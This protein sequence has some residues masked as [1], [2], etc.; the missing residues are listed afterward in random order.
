MNFNSIQPNWPAPKGI[1]AL[2]ST[3][4]G[5]VSEGLYESLNLAAHV[6]DEPD[7]VRE[8]RLRFQTSLGLPEEPCWLNQCHGIRAVELFPDTTHIPFSADA[9]YTRAAGKVCAVLTADCLPVLLCDQAGTEIAA[10]HAGW[11]GLADG[12]IES[13]IRC[14]STPP[15]EL[16]AWLG[17]AAS[18]A[19]YQV[20]A[21]VRDAFL[22][23]DKA[24]ENAFYAQDE[25]HWLM[26][27]YH[28]ARQRLHRLG[29]SAIYGGGYCSYTETE[30]FFSFR[31]SAVTGRMATVI[32]RE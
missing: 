18:A 21:D 30:R 5:G 25:T 19:I 2:T 29:V 11:R 16:M 17:P 8:N 6:G 14:L 31:R 13:T 12:V 3:R 32:W 28:L 20:G 24:A 10:I 4:K 27:I 22:S 15:K 1:R 23:H 7:R 9:V 26:D